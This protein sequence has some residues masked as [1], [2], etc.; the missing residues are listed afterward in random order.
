MPG[1]S[2]WI[3]LS[4]SLPHELKHAAADV[5]RAVWR[6]VGGIRVGELDHWWHVARLSYIPRADGSPEVIIL[7][8]VEGE[9]DYPSQSAAYTVDITRRRVKIKKGDQG[10]AP[11]PPECVPLLD[12]IQD[13]VEKIPE[14]KEESRRRAERIRR[15]EEERRRLAEAEQE[16]ARRAAVADYERRLAN[17]KMSQPASAK[18]VKLDV[19]PSVACHQPGTCPDCAAPLAACKKC[20]Q[21]SCPK[22]GCDGQGSDLLLRCVDHGHEIYCGPCRD[23]QAVDDPR[24]PLLAVCPVCDNVSCPKQLLFCNGKGGGR[25]SAHQIRVVCCVSCQDEAEDEDDTMVFVCVGDDCLSLQAKTYSKT[26]LCDGC[27]ELHGR[28]C[29]DHPSEWWCEKCAER[30]ESKCPS[31]DHLLCPQIR[32]QSCEKCKTPSSCKR[33]LLTPADP[34]RLGESN[35]ERLGESNPEHLG[36]SSHENNDLSRE[37][38]RPTDDPAAA[39]DSPGTVSPRFLTPRLEANNRNFSDQAPY[40]QAPS[41]SVCL[42]RGIELLRRTQ[43]SGLGFVLRTLF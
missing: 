25:T 10:Y 29:E 23:G 31:C 3:S 42:Y 18:K 38:P 33:C 15:E 35:P 41:C 36:E 21:L 12:R 16:R 9:A 5:A 30:M 7:N 40:R 43:R 1:N 37:A 32:R 39:S 2:N 34:E 24:N 4:Q 13:W 20:E 26:Y 19:E 17:F 28:R 27:A 8:C 22:P 14:R 11:I 6:E